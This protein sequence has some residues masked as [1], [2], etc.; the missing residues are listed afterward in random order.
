MKEQSVLSDKVL[1]WVVAGLILVLGNFP[2]LSVL[3]AAGVVGDGTP[4]SC[5]QAAFTTALTGGGTV[6]FNCGGPKIILVFPNRLNITADTVIK[7][8]GVITLT[9]GLN[10]GLFYVVAPASLTLNDITLDSAYAATDGDGGAIRASGPL[11]LD[12]VT[13]QYSQ[14]TDVYCGGA[15]WS[16]GAVSISNSIFKNNTGGFGGGAI[17]TGQFGTTRLQVNNSAFSNNQ[18]VSTVNGLGGA[19]FVAGPVAEVTIVDSGFTSN[20]ARFGGALAVYTGGTA[21]IRGSSTFNPVSFTS[22]SAT[23]EGGAIWNQGT[24]KVYNGNFL[25]NK[26]P[27]NVGGFGGGIASYGGVTLWDSSFVFSEGRYG[28]GLFVGTKAGGGSAADVRRTLF[29]LGNALEGGGIYTNDANAFV[30]VSDS[31]FS[32]NTAAAG[33]GLA[34]LNSRVDISNSSFTDNASTN[35]GGGLWITHLPANTQDPSFVSLTSV[36]ISRNIANPGVKH[37][38]GYY[39]QGIS[40]LTN[41]TIKDN[42]N[43]IYNTGLSQ[44][45]IYNTVLDNPNS[46]NCDGGT[47]LTLGGHNL[48]TDTSCGVEQNGV[49]AQ[50]GDPVLN[51][52][53]INQT[54][55]YPPLAGSPL[56]NAAAN[57]PT[58]DQRGASRPDKCDIG[59]VEYGGLALREYLPI[60][61]KH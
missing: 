30:S 5:T 59:A 2:W 39:N 45:N 47:P 24:L 34:R 53:G 35:D 4:A 55:Y 57:C 9:G 8:G 41:V 52:N 37:G 54:L 58:L 14:T 16:N 50:L 32:R 1:R 19:I 33:G 7:G 60:I 12:N 26:V 21:T 11:T 44:L 42:T 40:V 15:I 17:C 46:L 29:N 28:A 6:T 18:T 27:L 25:T 36:T 20:T 49:T 22:N 48:S 61:E 43:G 13:I 31:V 3:E 38:G 56:I 23:Q 10:N 51:T